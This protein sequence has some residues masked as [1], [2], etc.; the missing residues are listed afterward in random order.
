MSKAIPE[1]LVFDDWKMLTDWSL[2]HEYTLLQ[3]NFNQLHKIGQHRYPPTAF[4]LGQLASKVWLSSVVYD[5][6]GSVN[7]KQ[8]IAYLGC[9]IGTLAPWLNIMFKPDRIFG[10][11]VDPETIDMADDYN[12][13]LVQDNWRFKGVVED[14]TIIDWSEP[15]FVVEGELITNFAPDVIV[16]T[17]SEH[18]NDDWFMSA[19]R[20]TLVI[21]QTNNYFAWTQEHVNCVDSME[22]MIKQYPMRKIVYAGEMVTPAYTRYM[23]IG[24]PS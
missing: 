1:K 10:F 5:Q 20:D 6:I 24:Y 3:P 16:N 2:A 15:E 18:M 19:H 12:N 8:N 4:S 22:T 11:D 23:Q 7:L 21:M 13:E 14:A 9:W 17:S